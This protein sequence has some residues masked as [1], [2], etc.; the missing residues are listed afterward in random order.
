MSA[1]LF[2][3]ADSEHV[4]DDEIW[5]NDDLSTEGQYE[6]LAYRRIYLVIH[7][8]YRRAW[9]LKECLSRPGF[10]YRTVTVFMIV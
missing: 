2:S 10:M 9:Y 1:L 6:F 3:D 7:L 4:E 5:L 8:A